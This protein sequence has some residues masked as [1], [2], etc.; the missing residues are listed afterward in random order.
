MV[1]ATSILNICKWI[2]DAAAVAAA[3]SAAIAIAA[4]PVFIRIQFI[5]T[6]Q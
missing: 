6:Q 3:C 1:L 5:N 2:Y 4:G